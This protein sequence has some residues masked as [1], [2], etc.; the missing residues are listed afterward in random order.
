MRP[1][2]A[3]NSTAWLL[4]REDLIWEGL[5]R[6]RGYKEI[7]VKPSNFDLKGKEL[8]G[9]PPVCPKERYHPM[10]PSK[11]EEGIS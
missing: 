7:G 5:Y 2:F 3:S 10:N 4:I 1:H 6:F 11:T 8:S 9:Y